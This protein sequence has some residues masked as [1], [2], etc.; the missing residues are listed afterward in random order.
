MAEDI[1]KKT[2]ALILFCAIILSVVST[3]LVLNKEHNIDIKK[4][5]TVGTQGQVGLTV[6]ENPNQE[7]SRGDVGLTIIE[8]PEE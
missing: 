8:P 5:E 2:V 1:S 6:L 3:F 4:F 7:A